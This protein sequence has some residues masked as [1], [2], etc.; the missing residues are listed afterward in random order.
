MANHYG[1]R[2]KGKIMFSARPPKCFIQIIPCVI[3]AISCKIH[4]NVFIHDYQ[5]FA[6]RHDATPRVVTVKQS[7]W[8]WD[9]QPIILLCY[10]QYSL[11]ISWKSV[12]PFST[13]LLWCCFM[14][15][16]PSTSTP[17]PEKKCKNPV[18]KGLN[19]IFPKCCRMFLLPSPTYT[20]YSMKTFIFP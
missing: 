8:V 18:C 13:M 2:N 17:P 6:N 14:I 1:S 16:M 4:E 12:Y 11:K 15:R 3:P 7:S 9:S 5:N 10:I 20:E 19:G